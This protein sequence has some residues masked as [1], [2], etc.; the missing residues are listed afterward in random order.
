M[1][2]QDI[3]NKIT[4]IL[5]RHDVKKASVFGSYAR[6]EETK[7]SD[8]DILIEYKNDDKSLYDLA[9]L[10]IELEERLKKKVDLGEYST[11]RP[12]IKDRILS[13]QI[14]IL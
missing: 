2:I 1:S 14:S 13:E 9:E 12:Q 10:Q 11:I 4:P 8:V 7:K 3:K 6:G 5:K